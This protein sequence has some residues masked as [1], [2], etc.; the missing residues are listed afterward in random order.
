MQKNLP[1]IPYRYREIVE[2]LNWFHSDMMFTQCQ[3]P[4]NFVR[5]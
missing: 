3:N 2:K 5:I 4:S 1:K